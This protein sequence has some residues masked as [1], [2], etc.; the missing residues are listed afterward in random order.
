M[1]S[2]RLCT[3]CTQH[4]VSIITLYCIGR[5][6]RFSTY[7]FPIW[8]P[9][10]GEFPQAIG[11]IFDMRKLKLLGYSLVKVARWSTQSFGYNTAR[12]QTHSHVATANAVRAAKTKRQRTKNKWPKFGKSRIEFVGE[13]GLPSDTTFLESHSKQELN[14]FSRIRIVKSHKTVWQTDWEM[15]VRSIAILCFLCVRCSLVTLRR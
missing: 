9:R 7:S 11:F 15:R 5:I 14:P 1:P 8:R 3:S 10:W 13:L 6:F 12:W 2:E 4:C